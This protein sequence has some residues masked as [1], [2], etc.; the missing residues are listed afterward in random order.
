MPK[1]PMEMPPLI[2]G[3]YSLEPVERSERG[4]NWFQYITIAPAPD[5]S[6]YTKAGIR[7]F[8]FGEMW[9]RA[10]LD[11]K[12]RR[13]I[14][15]AC[16]G[17]ADTHIPI[18]SHIF[19]ALRSGDVSIEEMREFNLQ[20]AAHAGWPKG[21]FVEQVIYESWE[22]IQTEAGEDPAIPETFMP[23]AELAKNLGARRQRGKDWYEY[24][25]QVPMKPAQS[26]REISEQEFVYGEIW[27]RPRLDVKA[28]RWISLT[29]VGMA[30]GREAIAKHMY[31]ALKSGDISETEMDEFV[32][33]FAVYL[34]WPKASTLDEVRKE[35]VQR[36][37]DE[38]GAAPFE[39][40][41]TLH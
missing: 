20:F 4:Q 9:C 13:L 41:A 14:T 15:V 37:R 17:V 30:D 23:S 19:S 32:L 36:L 7:N 12:S 38:D 1:N 8:V 27:C 2:N 25:M 33:H 31:G 10:G 40:P 39:K 16:C 26:A 3:D 35:V 21:S 18:K 28:R 5:G 22:Q 24:I 29:C 34:G 11:V 6:P